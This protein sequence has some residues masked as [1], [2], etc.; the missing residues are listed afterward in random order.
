M[1]G[2]AQPGMLDVLVCTN[3]VNYTVAVRGVQPGADRPALLLYEPKRFERQ[4]LP[5]V[6]HLPIGIWSLRLVRWLAWLGRVHTL[7]LPHHRFNPRIAA[8]ARH[9]GSVA[10]LDDGLDT[11]RGEPRNFD[12]DRIAG[13]PAYFTFRDYAALPQWLHRFDVR[14]VCQLLDL[15]SVSPRGAMALD[16]VDHVFFESP[17]LQPDVLIQRLKLD[18][19]RTLVVRHPIAAKRS[20]VPPECRTVNGT[21]FNP[22]ATLLAS[23][24]K[25]FYF[26]ETMALVFALHAGPALH[27]RVR[28]QLGPQQRNNLAAVG[29]QPAETAGDVQLF[30]PG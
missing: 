3:L 22:E 13:R 14:P 11:L 18:V 21:D 9:A 30:G 28:A 5:N 1:V 4:V 6:L 8:A 2:A 26:G 29:L 12:L 16:G 10:Y 25:A 24:G 27:N 20:A 17:G 15:A 23:K 7:Y 19:L